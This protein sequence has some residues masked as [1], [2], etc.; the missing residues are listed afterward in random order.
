MAELSNNTM[1]N[2]S[3]KTKIIFVDGIP[4][5]IIE[6]GVKRNII[7]DISE[8]NKG[9]V[10]F[11]DDTNLLPNQKDLDYE[12]TYYNIYKDGKRYTK[13]QDVVKGNYVSIG[14]HKIYLKNNNGFLSLVQGK[15][16]E[17]LYIQ[18]INQF[19]YLGSIN[20]ETKEISRRKDNNDNYIITNT[21]YS[22]N[23]DLVEINSR[24]NKFKV[25]YAVILKTN[26]EIGIDD[27]SG[28]DTLRFAFYVK[29]ETNEFESD[30]SWLEY[31]SYESTPETNEYIFKCLKPSKVTNKQIYIKAISNYDEEKYCY[32][33]VLTNINITNIVYREFETGKIINK[34]IYMKLNEELGITYSYEPENANI[35]STEISQNIVYYDL[36][37][38]KDLNN[39]VID[40]I[41]KFT[42]KPKF[43]IKAKQVTKNLPNGCADLSITVGNKKNIFNIYISK[44]AEYYWY[45]G[46]DDPTTLFG[47]VYDITEE[48]KIETDNS[49][50]GF[51]KINEKFV[52]TKDS[53]LLDAEYNP[54]KFESESYYYVAIPT[55]MPDNEELKPRHELYD[56]YL[57]DNENVFTVIN[58]NYVIE[59]ISYRI[60]KS[61]VPAK[62][63]AGKIF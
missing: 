15:E 47:Q 57:G 21:G 28:D 48:Y 22:Y 31:L 6:N 4:E 35:N 55:N 33:P 17:D 10:F 54:I 27:G 41:D 43:I 3:E 12:D 2:I 46:L 11:T 16:I 45:I 26:P 9:V 44:D 59:E 37:Q 56:A 49:K 20:G 32:Y 63:F 14:S 42:P 19:P 36:I 52:Y 62:Q 1:N 18:S 29:N 40:D 38:N 53:P 61:I 58:D 60:Y 25:K 24:D 50:M 51:H 34:D 5:N 30:T 7:G 23:P 8:K 13:F 39:N